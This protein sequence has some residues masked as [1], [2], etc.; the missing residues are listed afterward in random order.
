MADQV[1][2]GISYL[3]LLSG[4]AE[5]GVYFQILPVKEAKPVPSKNIVS[6]CA[7]QLFRLSDF[8]LNCLLSFGCL[9]VVLHSSKKPETAYEI[10]LKIS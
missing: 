6:L 2:Y 5:W 3:T 1:K 4:V 10:T 7:P 8:P 9:S